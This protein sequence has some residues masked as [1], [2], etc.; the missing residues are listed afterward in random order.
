[1]NLAMNPVPGQESA[2]DFVMCLLHVMGYATRANRRDLR[3]RKDIPYLICGE[4]RHARTDVCVM[5]TD[6]ILC[7]VQ[8]DKHHLEPGDPHPQLIAEAI[9]A[10]QS[11]NLMRP[12]LGSNQLDFKDMT[13]I[14]M[15][16]SSPT[17]FKIP[18]TRQLMQAVQR[19]QLPPTPTVVAMHRPTFPRP[20]CCLTEGMQ[21]LDNRR[22]VLACLEA[23]RQFVRR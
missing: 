12:N 17:F 1:M 5:D 21:A 4:W 6:E 20:L 23:F 19:G 13:G 7:L 9:A 15:F 3:S 16:G 11:N 22:V 14:V 18:V 10:V 2:V 8:E